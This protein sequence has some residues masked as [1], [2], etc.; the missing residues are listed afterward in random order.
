MCN[1][2]RAEYDRIKDQHAKL[3]PATLHQP[4]TWN[5]DG[6]DIFPDS[7]APVVARNENMEFILRRMRWGMPGPPQYGGHPVTNIR[8]TKSPHW[9]RWLGPSHRALIPFT[10]FCEWEDTK[11]RKTPR[12]FALSDEQPVATFAGIWTPWTG[13]RGTKKDP[14]EGEHLLFGMLTTE[15][16][17]VVKPIHP[18]AMPV[19]LT[20][21]EERDIWLRAPWDEAKALQRPLPDHQLTL[22]PLQ[23][24]RSS[25][26]NP[27]TSTAG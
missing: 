12:W 19:I 24:E 14:I 20:T 6:K 21:A 23:A 5:D 27:N 4:V 11:P 7:Q 13:V 25:G 17:A 3:F 9:R 16:N 26:G 18:K 22:L 1:R 15:A 8:N 2:Y 10:S